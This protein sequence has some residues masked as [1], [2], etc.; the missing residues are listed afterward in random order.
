MAKHQQATKLTTA[1][2][3]VR[4]AVRKGLVVAV[5]VAFVVALVVADR[6]GL[7]GR[8]PVPDR[9]KYHGGNFRVARVLDGDTLD[10]D[11][12]DD[13]YN[14]VHT[15]IRLWG[16]DTPEIEKRDRSADHF[17][18][19]ASAMTHSLCDGKTVRIE[20]EPVRDTR[21][22]HGRLLAYVILPDGRMLN[23]LLIQEGY[24][25]ADPRFAH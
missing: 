16:I 23:R 1:R 10:I 17:G 11:V 5:V 3:R 20:L 13:R 9:R 22:V 15:R 2:R 21:G 7:F 24:G 12:P 19:E 6:H 18:P 25:Y 8:A 4:Y 14:S